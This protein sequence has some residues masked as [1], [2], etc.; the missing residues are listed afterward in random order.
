[1]GK[2]LGGTRRRYVSRLVP[3]RLLNEQSRIPDLHVLE[4]TILKLQSKPLS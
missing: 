4:L 1:M 3:G 2:G